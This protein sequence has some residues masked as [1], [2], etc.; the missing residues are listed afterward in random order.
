MGL[1]QV[2]PLKKGYQELNMDNT[3]KNGI[4]LKILSNILGS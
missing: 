2:V 4:D 1:T 3:K